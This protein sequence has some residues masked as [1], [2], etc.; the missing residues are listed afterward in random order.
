MIEIIDFTRK[1]LEVCS[2]VNSKMSI[3]Y[4]TRNA[5][6]VGYICTCQYS[7]T[8]KAEAEARGQL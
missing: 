1:F 3:Y 4:P 8:Q 6:V 5:G 7:N 2:Y